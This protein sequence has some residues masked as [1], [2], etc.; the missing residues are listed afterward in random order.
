MARSTQP[1]AIGQW[2]RRARRDAGFS[3]AEAAA[4]AAGVPPNWLRQ[5]EAGY[6]QRPNP[7]RLAALERLFGSE[8]PEPPEEFSLR[9]E[10]DRREMAELLVE[11]YERGL[12]KGLEIGRG[13]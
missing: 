5:L 4:Q 1:S 6:Y 8:A 13:G 11:A 9:D 3:S 2:A 10:E 7:E 12:A